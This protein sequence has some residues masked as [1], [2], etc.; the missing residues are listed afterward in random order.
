MSM[1][2]CFDCDELIDSDDDHECFVE[3]GNMRRQTSTICLCENC[4]GRREDQLE[5]EMSIAS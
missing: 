5:Y 3:V 1:V 2:I 4:R